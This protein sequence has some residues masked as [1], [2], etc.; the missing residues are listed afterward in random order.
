MNIKFL[1]QG[2]ALS[3]QIEGRWR[4]VKYFSQLAATAHATTR[5]LHGMICIRTR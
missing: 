5:S 1:K 4:K 2:N 3:V